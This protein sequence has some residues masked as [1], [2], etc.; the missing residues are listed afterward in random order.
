MMRFVFIYIFILCF[1][2]YFFLPQLN[3]ECFCVSSR[4][5]NVRHWDKFAAHMTIIPFSDHIS[6]STKTFQTEPEKC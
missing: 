6:Q 1:P 5:F 3:V 2:H 4:S